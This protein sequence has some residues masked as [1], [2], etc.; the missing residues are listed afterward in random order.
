MTED[1]NCDVYLVHEA[2]AASAVRATC[3]VTTVAVIIPI[4]IHVC[5][6]GH[7]HDEGSWYFG[8]FVFQVYKLV[9]LSI[10]KAIEPEGYL[11]G[12]VG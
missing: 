10:R 3:R 7:H 11:Q 1:F 4:V 8:H 2:A 12:T 5:H 6:H 9:L